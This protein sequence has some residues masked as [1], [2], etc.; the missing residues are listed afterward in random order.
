MKENGNV[1]VSL[2]VVICIFIIVALLGIIVGLYY[3]GFIEKNK[4]AKN[5]EDTNSLS[6]QNSIE[7]NE[8]VNSITNNN[9]QESANKQVNG[10]KKVDESKELVY[11]K[12]KKEYL[13][14]PYINIDSKDVKLINEDINEIYNEMKTVGDSDFPVSYEYFINDNCLSLRIDRGFPNDYTIYT[15]Y[16][17]DINTGKPISN[18]EL[19]HSKNLTENEYLKVLSDVYKAEARKMVEPVEN[20][21]SSLSKEVYEKTTSSDNY[22]TNTPI[23]LDQNGKIN[24]IAKIYAIAGADSYYHI[25][26]T[27]K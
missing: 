19:I 17:I 3:F 13:D 6:T 7:T 8:P 1:K 14:V 18:L 23:Y 5:V 20:T 2:S 10:V 21:L 12:V 27:N 25:L 9:T 22:S 11:S 24:V 16:N 4:V 15:V 26:N